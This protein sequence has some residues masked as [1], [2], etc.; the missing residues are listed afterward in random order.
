MVG[1][2]E[3]EASVFVDE[4]KG[5]KPKRFA[6]PSAGVRSR[7]VNTLVHFAPCVSCRDHAETH[8]PNGYE[9]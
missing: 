1:V 8:Y 3:T 9:N 2:R 7:N 6:R 4:G 5:G